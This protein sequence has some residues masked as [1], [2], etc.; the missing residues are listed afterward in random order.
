MSAKRWAPS[1]TTALPIV[2]Q[3]KFEHPQL[4]ARPPADWCAPRTSPLALRVCLLSSLTL[5][6]NILISFFFKCLLDRYH[7]SALNAS[8]LFC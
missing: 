4:S 6:D 1:V 7:S 2:R 5:T 8:C 3:G